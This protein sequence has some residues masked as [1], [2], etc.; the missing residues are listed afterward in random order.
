VCEKKSKPM[1]IPLVSIII[2]SFNQGKFIERTILSVLEQSCTDYE[3][4]IVDAVST[5]E[6]G[7][8]LAHYADRCARVIIEKDK[9]QADAINK[10]VAVAKGRFVSWLNS[11]D[12]LLPG[13][14]EHLRLSVEKYPET[15]WFM[16]NTIWIDTEDKVIKCA[17]GMTYSHK[18]LKKY[19]VWGVPSPSAFIERSLWNEVGGVDDSHHYNFDIDLWLKLIMRGYAYQRIP[20]YCWGLRIHKES[21]TSAHFFAD[22]SGE[23]QK[24]LAR[25]RAERDRLAERYGL[26]TVPFRWWAERYCQLLRVVTGVYL[27]GLIDTLRYSRHDVR[28]VKGNG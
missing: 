9:G 4:I 22:A 24:H 17:R 11:D 12:L 20:H 15:R 7:A 16:G 1:S 21:K 27:L 5:D 3:L 18:L 19:R 26:N 28:T 8:V 23:S 25:R 2:P 14:L 6:T 13:T 10:G